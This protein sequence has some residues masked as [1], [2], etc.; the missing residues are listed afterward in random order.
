[1][2]AILEVPG[3]GKG[4]VA[5]EDIPKGTRILSE[6]PVITTPDRQQ[7]NEWLKTHISQQVDSLSE[8]QRGSFLSMHNLYPYNNVAEQSLGI[9]RT[10][11]L[12]IE[13]NG[14]GGGIFLEACRIN[15]ACD[16]NA[17]KNWNQCIQRHTV[18]ALRNI[19][20]GE[21]I[22]IY[23]LGLYSN[24]EVRQK[25]LLD[26][27]GFLCSCRLCSLPT[28]QSQKSD[29]RLTRIDHLDDLIGHDGMQLKFLLR[30]LR[31]VDERI[32]L[33]NEQNPDRSGLPR[34]YLDAAQI[35]IANGDLARGR[36]FAERAVEGWRTSYGSDSKEVI[37]H[38]P[39]AR[40]PAKLELYGLS[41]KW[42]TSLDDVPQDLDQDNFE[43]WL[44]RREKPKKLER[45]GQSIDLRNREIFPS[46]AALPNSNTADMDFYEKIGD[47]Y[48][49]LRHWCFLG[50]IV[51]FTTLHH[52]ELELMDVDD[53][54]IPLHFYTDDRGSK[55]QVQLGYT[56]AVLY[57]QRYRFIYGDA[58][59]RLEDYQMVKI[60]PIP[61]E[62]LLELN[63][64]VQQ[65]STEVDEVRICHGCG[66]KTASSKRCGRCSSFWYCNEVCQKAGWNE[67][68]HKANCKLLRDPDIRGLFVLKWDQFDNKLQFPLQVA[69]GS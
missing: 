61:L 63:D 21:E 19:S 47:V 44:W 30:T 15:H 32:R 54:K 16:N 51:D 28:E 6:G 12:P 34:A 58:G 7:N 33:Y 55:F 9:I 24:R 59:I 27:F 20:K 38:G 13:T 66:R 65:F 40:N 4:L 10:N 5:V 18:H 57:A 48:R 11:S 62:K 17:Q 26:K 53:K 36:I 37:E 42:K 8:H 46:F 60:F 31:F 67:K 22:T 68:G 49:P 64:Q 41:L 1:M 56:V 69:E 35:A 50:E 3:K 39:L 23:Y 14:I 52:L 29:E 25:K 2:Y 45:L 43:D